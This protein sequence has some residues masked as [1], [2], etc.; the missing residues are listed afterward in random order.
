MATSMNVSSTVW[1]GKPYRSSD[2]SSHLAVF[3]RGCFDDASR[4]F[5][6]CE[7]DWTDRELIDEYGFE[8]QPWDG[9]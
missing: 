8:L 7:R 4:P 2:H 9:V 5:P 6:L 3:V 1:M